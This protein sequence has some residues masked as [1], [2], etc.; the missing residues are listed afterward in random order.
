MKNSKIYFKNYPDIWQYNKTLAPDAVTYHSDWSKV[1]T[2]GKVRSSQDCLRM[3]VMKHF[4]THN[5]RSRDI[6][7]PL[8]P[9]TKLRD[10]RFYMH[11]VKRY[12]L[13]ANR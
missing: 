4:K 11:C 8:T 5:V 7:E 13:C 12:L 2:K 3:L 1:S 6:L 10:N 9:N